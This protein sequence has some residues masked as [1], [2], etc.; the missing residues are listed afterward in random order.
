MFF[1]GFVN[2]VLATYAPDLVH[3]TLDRTI[4]LYGWAL[5]AV[6]VCLVLFIAGYVG[7]AVALQRRQ[8]L[9]MPW[10]VLLA[11]GSVVF[12]LALLSHEIQPIV[13]ERIGSVPFALGL[14]FTMRAEPRRQPAA[15][16][17]GAERPKLAA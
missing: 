3:T 9:A 8:L 7:L 12:G 16:Q 13:I 14:I 11:L 10:A 1:D 2:P 6:G 4:Q 17:P 15:Q 5:I